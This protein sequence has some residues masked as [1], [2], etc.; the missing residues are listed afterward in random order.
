V[1]VPTTP[2]RFL[3]SI[4]SKPHTDWVFQFCAET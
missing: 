3:G 4:R 1:V 2:T